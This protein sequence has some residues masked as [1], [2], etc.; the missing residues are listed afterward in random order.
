MPSDDKNC[1][2]PLVSINK[3]ISNLESRS[4]NYILIDK[5]HNYE[6][7]EKVNYKR[8]NKYYELL[9]KANDYIFKLERINKIRNY[10]L[11][12]NSKIDE[13]EKILYAR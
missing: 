5:A 12:D 9:A 2:F 4:I 7:I 13:I 3:V 6:E 1:G 10:L 11:K 8:K